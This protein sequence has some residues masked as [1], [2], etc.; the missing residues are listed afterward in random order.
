[1][2]ITT[3]K[4]NAINHHAQQHAPQLNVEQKLVTQRPSLNQQRKLHENEI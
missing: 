4:L 1:M 3:K 2:L